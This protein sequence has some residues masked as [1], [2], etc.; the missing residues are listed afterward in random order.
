M[1]RVGVVALMSCI[2][3]GV[4]ALPRQAAEWP[5]RWSAILKESR[6]RL[7][8]GESQSARRMLSRLLKEVIEASL[9]SDRT[10]TLLADVLM[11]LALAEA[12]TGADDDAVWHWEIAQ[13]I[14]RDVASADLSAFGKPADLLTSNI[15]PPAPGQCA[16]PPGGPSS[17]TIKKRREPEY[18]RAALKSGASGILIVQVELNGAGQPIRPQLLRKQPGALVF[19]TLMSL[20]EWR[21]ETKPG[22]GD[23]PFCLVFRFG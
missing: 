9:P 11:Q 6:D 16:Q 14:V 12:G 23:Q 22:A 18:P 3:A 5:E 10:D 4:A 7:T 1:L 21:F 19:A 13:N 15:L 2:S 8:S 17:P 20:R